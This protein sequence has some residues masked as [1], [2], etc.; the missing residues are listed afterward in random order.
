LANL[1]PHLWLTAYLNARAAGGKAPADAVNFLPWNLSDE[2]KSE[3]SN[4]REPPSAD[5]S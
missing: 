1:N 2:Q 4:D 5:T 3:W